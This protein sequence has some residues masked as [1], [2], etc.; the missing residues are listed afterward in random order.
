MMTTWHSFTINRSSRW[1]VL[2]FV[3][4]VESKPVAL[5]S[6]AAEPSSTLSIENPRNK[7]ELLQQFNTNLTSYQQ[8]MV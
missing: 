8:H 7:F 6:A 4:D 1:F 3:A 2:L 5:R